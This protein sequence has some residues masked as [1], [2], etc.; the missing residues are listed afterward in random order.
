[1]TGNGMGIKSLRPGLKNPRK[2]TTY[3]VYRSLGDQKEIKMN[4]NNKTVRIFDDVKINVKIKL[5][6]LWVTLM[7]FYIYADILGFYTPGN[8]EKI[9]SGM[10]GGVQITEIFL[11]V[12]AVWMAIPSAMV[13]LSLSLKAHANRWVNIIVGL[14]SIFILGATF[15]AGEVSI[16]YTFQAA[17]EAVLMAWIV[18]QAWKWPRQDA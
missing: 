17:L 13:F 10:I 6:A 8:I 18:W 12:M 9:A 3:S 15:F 2:A 7:L 4:A 14:V 11:V 5:S 1:M 16:R